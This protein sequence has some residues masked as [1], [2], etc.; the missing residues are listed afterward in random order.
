MKT[1]SDLSTKKGTIAKVLTDHR[2]EIYTLI[3]QNKYNQ[4][5]M[6]VDELLNDPSLKGNPATAE[7]RQTLKKCSRNPNL[8][9]STLITYMTGVKVI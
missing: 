2:N 9:Y 5:Q 4:V 8:Y 7:A 6:K 3:E 1:D